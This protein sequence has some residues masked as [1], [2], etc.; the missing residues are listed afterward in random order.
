MNVK[1]ETQ[2]T[3]SALRYR[4]FHVLPERYWFL[5][6]YLYTCKLLILLTFAD[7]I[8]F[9][10]R[11]PGLHFAMLLCA[12]FGSRWCS[13]ILLLCP[14]TSVWAFLD[15]S[16]LPLSTLLLPLQRS[17]RL[18]FITWPYHE[19]HFWVTYVVIGLHHS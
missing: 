10:G 5:N 16:S 19:R 18:F 17:C 11:S 4:L 15:V 8:A 13:F 12:S 7:L 14:S 1:F 3:N 6:K 2:T 9:R